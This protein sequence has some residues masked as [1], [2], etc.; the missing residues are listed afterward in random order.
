MRHAAS[1]LRNHPRLTYRPGLPLP[2]YADGYNAGCD[3][4][5]QAA[6]TITTGAFRK[7]VLR[8]LKEATYAQGWGDGYEQC[9][10]PAESEE[11]QRY[12]DARGNHHEHDWRQQKDRALGQA[13]RGE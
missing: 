6:G 1:G 9:R 2:A 4:G 5:R 13:L 12:E 8:Y 7:D 10:R 11:R 3:S